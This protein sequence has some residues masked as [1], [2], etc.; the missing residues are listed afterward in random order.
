[1]L[2]SKRILFDL[3]LDLKFPEIFHN[4]VIVRSWVDIPLRHEFRAFVYERRLCALSQYFTQIYFPELEHEMQSLLPRIQSFFDSIS[5]RFP[6]NFQNYVIDFAISGEQVLVLEL[7][8]YNPSTGAG[9]F[10][11]NSQEDCDIIEGKQPF[12]FRLVKEPLSKEALLRATPHE[13]HN[14]IFSS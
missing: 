9:L 6:P 2:R 1:M 10:D 14:F 12:E 4:H 8:P 7:N 5:T 13:W 3:E 11:W